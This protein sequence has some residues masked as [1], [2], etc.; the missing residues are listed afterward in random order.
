MTRLMPGNII[1]KYSFYKLLFL[2]FFL[3]LLVRLIY[4]F[5]AYQ[6]YG[7]SNFS[8]DW[9]YIKFAEAMLRQ[10]FF[11]T[12]I[13]DM[14]QTKSGITPL[15]PSLIFLSFKVF[16][17]AY[18]P[19][20]I[21]N[22]VL[23]S[24]ITI[25]IFFIGKY[26]FNEYVGLLSSFW[27]IFYVNT[28]RWVPTL[29]KESL[30]QFLFAL[31]VLLILIYLIKNRSFLTLALLTFVFAL[32]IHTDER[33]IIYYVVLVAVI[34]VIDGKS[35]KQ[36]LLSFVYMNL[37]LLA[38]M[39]P[40]FIRNYEVYNR[41]VILSERTAFMTDKLFGYKNENYY[42]QEIQISN[43]TLDSIIKGMPVQDMTMYN[44][45]QRG[46]SYGSYPRRYSKI[47]KL[48]IDFKEL[49][50]PFRFSDMWVS[51]GFRP[52]GKWSVSHNISLILTYGVLLPFFLIGLYDSLKTKNKA[53]LILLSIVIIHT[54]IHTTFVLSQNRYRIPLDVIIIVIA[55]Y[56]L[57]EILGKGY[58]LKAGNE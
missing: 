6:K 43:A 54:I 14:T 9:V 36:K 27:T 11:V 32:L 19:L 58:R 34:I 24:F 57:T 25:I 33:Y 56:G 18:L 37:L 22:A 35:I 10:G 38:F 28:I 30:I 44:L 13:S 26:S 49:W 47:E 46:M 15:Y 29:L 2:F 45:I 31:L 52:E 12:D 16:G 41:P 3:S 4:G 51:E 17:I 39:T 7:S 40:W 8:D 53:S 20:V 48:Y 55:F 5:Y 23:S 21:I 42:S 1:S 50:R